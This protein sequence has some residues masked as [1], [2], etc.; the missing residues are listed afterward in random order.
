MV[1]VWLYQRYRCMCTS[2]PPRNMSSSQ[3][4]LTANH[5]NL[6]LLL[7]TPPENVLGVSCASEGDEI[8]FW[9][10]GPG[11]CKGHWN[12]WV[13]ELS[14][15]KWPISLQQVSCVRAFFCPAWSIFF[16]FLI[17][18]VRIQLLAAHLT[19]LEAENKVTKAN[20]QMYW[21][22]ISLQGAFSG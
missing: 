20:L 21:W 22:T 15:S 19:V 2:Q 5:R 7:S 11:E 12:S 8:V 16:F 1:I 6:L 9:R 18:F 17:Y 14:N 10:F 13:K 3:N 4:N